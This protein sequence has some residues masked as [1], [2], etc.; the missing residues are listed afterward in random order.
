MQLKQPKP[1]A[2]QIANFRNTRKPELSRISGARKEL[3]VSRTGRL[4]NIGVFRHDLRIAPQTPLA[5]FECCPLS[6]DPRR[7]KPAVRPPLS[8]HEPAPLRV[9]GEAFGSHWDT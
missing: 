7:L 4:V 8:H 1:L 2:S 3:L 9:S 6:G 5:G